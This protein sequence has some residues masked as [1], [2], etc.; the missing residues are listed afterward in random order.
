MVLHAIK[1]V[2]YFSK[3]ILSRD[4]EEVAKSSTGILDIAST[5]KTDDGKKERRKRVVEIR[6]SSLFF[7]NMTSLIYAFVWGRK[8]TRVSCAVDISL[9]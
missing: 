2:L 6:A 4:S 5:A 7:I 3:E 9:L 1:S 8:V